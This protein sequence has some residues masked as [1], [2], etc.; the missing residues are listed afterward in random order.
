MRPPRNNVPVSDAAPSRHLRR[1]LLASRD[2]ITEEWLQRVAAFPEL[3]RLSK[4]AVLDHMP[5][6]LSE[7]AGA[8][9]EDP[10]ATRRA[11]ER[12][13]TGHAL[14]RLGFG[15]SVSTLLDEY[16]ALREVLL[17]HLLRAVPAGGDPAD[18]LEIERMLDLSISESIRMFAAQRDEVRQQLIG[19]LGHDLRGP[20]QALLGGAEKILR[21]PGCGVPAHAHAAA[22]IRNTAERMSRLIAD[23]IDFTLGQL[24]RA[25]P[26]FPVVCDMGEVCR[27]V[28]DE[29]RVA[30]PDRM[31][32]VVTEGNLIGS[33]DRDR[34]VQAISNLVSNALIHGSDPITLRAF[35]DP[36]REAVTTE[37]HNA[38]PPIPA[39][40]IPHL[41]DAYRRGKPAG[42][43]LGLGL[44]IVQQIAHAHGGACTVRSSEREGTTFSIR[45]P[46]T[47]L[48]E[49]P[50]AAA[51]AGAGAIS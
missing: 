44:Y 7:L 50:V 4:A 33:W 39:E 8:D 35:E 31:L 13:I 3:Q 43:G 23:I 21:Q 49:A 2:E 36:D 25:I 28:V 27:E 17:H 1:R 18:I 37:V 40:L 5:E 14:Q 22:A 12:L 47:M 10:A 24:G 26:A 9:A 20:L 51:A 48:A 34:V 45:W 46:R 29:L 19:V 30:H 38:G 11:C 42:N 41:F 32:S 15:V 6:F 16:S